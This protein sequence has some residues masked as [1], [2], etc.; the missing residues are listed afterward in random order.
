MNLDK[1]QIE[2]LIGEY[3]V[4][5]RV[6]LGIASRTRKAGWFKSISKMEAVARDIVGPHLKDADKD[7]IGIVAALFMWAHNA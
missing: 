6:V 5:T 2:S 3:S 4:E 7:F 1:V